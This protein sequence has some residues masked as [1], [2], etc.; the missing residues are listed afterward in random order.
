MKTLGLIGGTSWVSTV[1]YY[2]IINEQINQR[3]GGLNAA[4][5]ILYSLNYEEF[6][7]PANPADWGPT[8]EALAKIAKNL[9]MSGAECIVLCANTPHMAAD[10]IQKQIGIPLI[11]IAEETAKEI[12]RHNI[13]KVGL[14][15][16]KLT[17]EQSF[18]KEKL[19]KHGIDVLLPDQTERT[20]VHTTIFNELGKGN[21]SEEIKK[22]YVSIMQSLADKGA[23][24]IVLGCTEIPMLVK[25][26]DS[27]LKLFDTMLIHATAAVNFALENEKRVF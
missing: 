19:F 2:K 27:N 23:E 9:E 18:F 25:E 5:L 1:D 15:G 26:K 24:A 10:F 6:K 13:T 16:T 4:R 17:M 12:A 8:S 14:L 7:P 22:K 21:F 11:H 3:L 20:Y